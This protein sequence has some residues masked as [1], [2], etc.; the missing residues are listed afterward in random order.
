MFFLLLSSSEVAGVPEDSKFPRLG[1]W[2]SSSHFVQSG[3][4]TGSQIA[5]LTHGRCFGHNFCFNYPNGSYKPILD[6]YVSKYFQ[7]YKKL[8]NP[9]CFD[10][11]NHSNSQSGSSLGSVKV[12]SLTLSCTPKNMKCDSQASSRP[13]PL[14]ALALVTSSKLGL[15]Q[16]PYLNWFAFTIMFISN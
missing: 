8:L 13:T 11:F 12:H 9:M 4:V 14:Q 2:V 1:V 16:V 7:W 10:P 5:N 15:W 3:V 6:I